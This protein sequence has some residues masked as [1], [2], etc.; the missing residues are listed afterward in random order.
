MLTGPQERFWKELQ[1]KSSHPILIDSQVNEGVGAA[2][3]LAT[4]PGIYLTVSPTGE[5]IRS[6]TPAQRQQVVHGKVT[7]PSPSATDVLP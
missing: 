5:L 6:E 3:L 1:N 7:S 4:F 2:V